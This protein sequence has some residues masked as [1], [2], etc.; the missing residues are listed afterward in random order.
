MNKNK[1][2]ATLLVMLYFLPF[3]PFAHEILHRL[4]PPDILFHLGIYLELLPYTIPIVNGGGNITCTIIHRIFA[5]ENSM[6]DRKID[7]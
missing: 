3:L 6:V 1:S 2:I 4:M 7:R 5:V